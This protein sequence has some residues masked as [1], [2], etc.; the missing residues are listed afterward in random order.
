MDPFSSLYFWIVCTKLF[1][2]LSALVPN[3]LVTGNLWF[4]CVVAVELIWLSNVCITF[5]SLEVNAPDYTADESV[6]IWISLALEIITE[7]CWDCFFEWWKDPT[8]FL[9][10]K[11][12]WFN[13]IILTISCWLFPRLNWF[14]SRIS[15][16]RIVNGG[17]FVRMLDLT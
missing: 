6:S 9:S 7:L 14:Y 16:S 2:L 13:V 5:L 11:V 15:K 3:Y 17:S 12:F 8:D 10:L 1:S 4:F